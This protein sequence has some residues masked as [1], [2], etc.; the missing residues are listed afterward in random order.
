MSHAQSNHGHQADRRWPWNRRWHLLK[1]PVSAPSRATVEFVAQQ[2]AHPERTDER[3][4][5]DTWHRGERQDHGPFRNVDDERG[6]R[7]KAHSRHRGHRRQ[8]CHERDEAGS[9]QPHVPHLPLPRA[10]SILVR[11][12]PSDR[13][14]RGIP[15][16][17]EEHP[18]VRSDAAS[19]IRLNPLRLIRN[20]WRPGDPARS[21]APRRGRAG[22]RRGGCSLSRDSA[23]R[24]RA[25]VR[26]RPRGP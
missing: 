23:R 15:T 24:R 10:G 17:Q 6:S 12:D 5:L 1:A 3:P 21:T 7:I 11:E 16:G 18:T 8:R 2:V 26:G 19:D 25:P 13:T 9:S 14:C 4:D 22:D 20:R